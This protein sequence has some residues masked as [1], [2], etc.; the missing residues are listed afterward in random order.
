VIVSNI[1]KAVSEGK[2]MI[3]EGVHLDLSLYV[4]ALGITPEGYCA[5]NQGI[6]VPFL[7]TADERTHK[8]LRGC[9]NQESAHEGLRYLQ[10]Y[11]VEKAMTLGVECVPMHLAP[12]TSVDLLHSVA[13]DC[14]KRLYE[15]LTSDSTTLR[16]ATAMHTQLP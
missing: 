5:S 12:Q 10:D 9:S 14:M 16:P 15:N 1:K 4:P 8:Y 11:M 3:V 6:I 7:L 13:L 2:S